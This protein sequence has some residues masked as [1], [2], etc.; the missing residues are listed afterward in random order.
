M[1]MNK[2]IIA[3]VMAFSLIASS[4]GAKKNESKEES[5]EKEPSA[6][7]TQSAEQE[8]EP[9]DKGNEDKKD[10]EDKDDEKPDVSPEE[11]YQRVEGAAATKENKDVKRETAADAVSFSQPSG[12]YPESFDLTLTA[13]ESGEIYY[14]TD[15]SDPAMSSTAQL[16]SEPIKIADRSGDKN[17]VSAVDPLIM[18]GT[19]NEPERG[20]ESFRSTVS[21]PDDKSVDKCTVVRAAV[22]RSDGSFA[23]GKSAT[24]FLGTA[25]E[26]IAG[27]SESCEAAGTS[28]A[29]VSISMNYDDLFDYEEGIYVKG[30]IF[31][32]SLDDEIKREGGVYESE[33]ARSL[34]A[35]YKQRGRDWEREAVVTFME[36]S[37]DGAEEEFTQGCGVRIQGN[38][39]RSD[40]QKGFRLFARE[41]YGEKNFKY[42]VFGEDYLNDAGEVMDKY[43]TLVLRAG[44]NCAFTAKFN[45]TY[46]QSMLEDT[47][48]DTKQSRP[49][50]VYLNGE[51]WGLYVLEEDYSDDYF[52]DVH[53]VAKDD[54]VLYKGDAEKYSLGYKLDEGD[55]PEGEREDYYFSDLNA[56]FKSHKDVKDD[57][58]YEEL[59]KLVD[60]ESVMD[61]FAVECWINNKWDWPGKNWSMW[62]TVNTDP[63]NPYADG[64]WRF[65]FYDMEFGGVS[66]GQDAYTNTIKEDNYKPNGLLDMGTNNPAVLSFAYLMTNE[67]FRTEF[68]DR[69]TGLSEGEFEQSAALERLEWFKAVYSPLYD[70]FFERY[71]GTGDTDNALYGGYASAQCIADFLDARADN[72][73]KMID[74][75]DKILG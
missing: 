30:R 11:A 3:F 65:T 54:V 52:E 47:A 36:M 55:I 34:D 66:G 59:C 67:G 4:C 12:V 33:T 49:C 60:P 56:F 31:D 16:Y 35:N 7:S 28:L 6:A 50:V 19:F 9:E 74:Y 13:Q 41:S 17:I 8:N 32:E 68:Y 72:I 63:E 64:R 15:G 46:W 43:D 2:K 45:D 53:G 73:D 58:D 27:L 40:L 71:P 44:G 69:L 24:Y 5:S 57:A 29:V 21:A 70:Q 39:S 48:V 75:C 38:Y 20:H 18:A 1:S 23:E 14:T 61:Y 42:P 26:H 25:E 22:R 37:P 10:N 51:Y 62:K